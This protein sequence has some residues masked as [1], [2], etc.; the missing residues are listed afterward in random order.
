MKLL[1]NYGLFTVLLLLNLL[2]T[3]GENNIIKAYKWTCKDTNQLSSLIK[4][5]DFVLGK[6][7]EVNK[8]REN[9]SFNTGFQFYNKIDSNYEITELQNG[10]SPIEY[11]EDSL[12][13]H[14]LLGISKYGCPIVTKYKEPG[15]TEHDKY[16]NTKQYIL[17]QSLEKSAYCGLIK[18]NTQEQQFPIEIIEKSQN[19]QEITLSICKPS[20][21]IHYWACPVINWGLLIGGGLAATYFTYHKWVKK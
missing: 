13:M 15:K 18:C 11:T 16:I 21:T 20:R 8:S 17:V 7:Y 12:N 14:D 4:A 6:L 2:I 1:I 19:P 3:C 9:T 10:V 5:S